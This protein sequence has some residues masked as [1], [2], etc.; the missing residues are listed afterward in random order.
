MIE[1]LRFVAECFIPF[2][3]TLFV[4]AVAGYIYY[5]IGKFALYSLKGILHPKMAV[6]KASSAEIQT[7]HTPR[8]E[9]LFFR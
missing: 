9:G 1:A 7:P 3:F 5:R 2:L 6:P 4:Y 8:F